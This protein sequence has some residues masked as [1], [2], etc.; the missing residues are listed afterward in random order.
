MKENK[1]KEVLIELTCSSW[2]EPHSVDY[3]AKHWHCHYQC[4]CP[5]TVSEYDNMNAGYNTS[6]L[7]GEKKSLSLCFETTDLIRAMEY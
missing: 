1:R 5:F 7:T 3:R 2:V 4:G 6:F